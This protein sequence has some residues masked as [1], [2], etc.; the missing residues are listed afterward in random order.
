MPKTTLDPN[1]LDRRGR[2]ILIVAGLYNVSFRSVWHKLEPADYPLQIV[3]QMPE[4]EGPAGKRGVNEALEVCFSTLCMRFLHGG[5]ICF[6]L[7]ARGVSRAWREAIDKALPLLARIAF[8]VHVTGPDVVAVLMRAAGTSL[9]TVCFEGCRQLS[10][11]DIGCII[12]CLARCPAVMEVNITGCRE[13][14]IVR[15]LAVG[16]K[17]AVGAISPAD[18]RALL[19]E[20]AEGEGE[21]RCPRGRLVELLH[22]RL[23]LS[24]DFAPGQD[25]FLKAVKCATVEEEDDEDD[26]EVTACVYEAAVLEACCWRG[27]DEET[28]TFDFDEKTRRGKCALHFVAQRGGPLSLL[29]LL[30]SAGARVDAKDDVSVLREGGSA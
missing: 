25:A 10:G 3:G 11:A 15:A 27:Q 6:L 12:Q 4:G 17:K 14:V 23:L 20:Q 30:M 9:K 22:P 28:T 1:I 21:Y 13:E 24:Q 29:T 18:L 2:P 5:G 16:A 19:L 26:E 7:R 8:P